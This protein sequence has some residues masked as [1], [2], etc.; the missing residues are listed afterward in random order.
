MTRRSVL[1]GSL[2]LGL[3][4]TGVPRTA[5]APAQG[6]RPPAGDGGAGLGSDAP[7]DSFLGQLAATSRFRRG[8]PT[9]ISLTPDGSAV[10]FLRSGPRSFVQDLHEYDVASGRERVLLTADSLLGGGSERLTPEELA[11]RERQ[12][13]TARGIASYQLSRD[14]RRILVPLSGRLFVVERAGGAVRELPGAAGF[15]ID[16]RFSPDGSR[17]A[18]VRDHDLYVTEIASGT[19]R[20]LTEGGGGP[21]A[22]GEAE[23][24]AQEEMDRHE[25][26]WWSPDGGTIAYQRTDVTGVE[27]LSISDPAHPERPAQVWPYPRP[28]KKNAEVTLGLIAANG[29]PTTWVTWNR[30][31]YPYLATV[32]WKENAPLTILVQNRAQTEEVLL[33]VDTATGGTTP[34]LTERD[35]A[36]LNLFAGMPRWSK[37]GRSFLWMTERNGAPQLELRSREGRL[38]RALTPPEPGLRAGVDLDEARGVVWVR[39]GDDPKQVHLFRVPLEAKRGRRVQVTREPGVH[40][41]VFSEDKSVWVNTLNPRVG[42][43]SW[44]VRDHDGRGRG[45]LRSVAETP[46]VT[47]RVE[48]ATVG[49]SLRFHAA[50]LRPR[51]FVPGQRYPVIVSVYGGPHAQTVTASA[52]NY[53]VQQWLADQGFVVVSIDGRGTPGRGRAWER[54]IRGDLIDLPLRDQVA[55]LEALGRRYPELD[56]TRVGIT[57]WSFGAYFAALALERRPDVFHAGVAGAPVTDWRDYDTHYTER[58]MGLPEENVAGY[59]ASSALTWAKDLVR[60]LLILHGTADDN[61]YFLHSL[62]LCDALFRAGRSVELVP[63][64]GY[65]HMVADSLGVTQV[66]Q[67]TVRHFQRHLGVAR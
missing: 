67:R 7:A 65:T 38:V 23:F 19:E 60:P 56:L 18:C 9:S 52:Q 24:V 59:Q 2:A 54:A 64:R 55:A 5:S 13:E 11:R 4:L 31:G 12:R 30:Q 8:R 58:Y 6:G 66:N 17:I 25:G 34:L 47:P 46:R 50:L 43:A 10:L 16:A 51:D 28:G 20:R 26:Y 49:D 21:I 41:G 14:G 53:L 35:E 22:H 40:G 27:M 48:Y 36:W 62:N 61:V 1:A 3:A 33:A 57:G 63:L 44:T 29:G 37:D 15:P 39:A 42:L 32:V 45:A